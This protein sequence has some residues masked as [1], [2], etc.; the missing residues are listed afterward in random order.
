MSSKEDEQ[1]K[2]VGFTSKRE[3]GVKRGSLTSGR[4]NPTVF[5][6]FFAI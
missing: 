6:L 4:G 5:A 2:K 1:D 3:K